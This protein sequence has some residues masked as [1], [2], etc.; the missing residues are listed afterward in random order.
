M[1]PATAESLVTPVCITIASSGKYAYV[2]NISSNNVSQYEIDEHG[3][4]RPIRVN[5]WGDVTVAA[6]ISPRSVISVVI[7]TGEA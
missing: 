5:A 2:T 7:K 4:L 6:E 3:A 1:I